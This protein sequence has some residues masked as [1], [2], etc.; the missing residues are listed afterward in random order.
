MP[1]LELTGSELIVHLRWWE[2]L[3][4]LRG[5]VRVP[6]EHIRGATEDNGFRG[7]ALGLRIP[8]TH[9]PGVITAGTFRRGGDRQF[10]YT[11][12]RLQTV[13][14]ELANDVWTRLIVGVPDACAV[15]ERIN[16]AIARR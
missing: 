5:T 16:A 12:P 3:L 4:A 7:M 10:V 11:R 14:I 13:V 6:L 15:A 1:R 9:V 8:G 2:S